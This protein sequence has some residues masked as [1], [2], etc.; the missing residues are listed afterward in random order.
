[1][2]KIV[3][4]VQSAVDELHKAVERQ[5]EEIKKLGEP[6]A[7]SKATIDKINEHIDELEVKIQR[8]NLLSTGSPNS[9]EKTPEQKARSASFFKYMRYGTAAMT[10]D[11]QKALVEDTTG[12]Y[13]V[14]PELDAEIVRSLPK[15]T[16]IRPMVTVRPIS[17]ES[18]KIRS[19]SEV[20]GG[21]GKLE[22]GGSTNESTLVPGAP[23]YQYAEDWIGL[24]KVGRDELAD[25]DFNLQA[26]VAD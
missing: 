18:L 23:T 21:W 1:M 25:S 7:E 16:V 8:Q 24:T 6:S 26:I 12:L 17:K 2:E 15:I 5:D 14:T 20:T 10:S 11:E 13:L 3:E 22:T 9:E 19:I 4:I